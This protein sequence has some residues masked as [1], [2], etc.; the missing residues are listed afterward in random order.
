MAKI[1]AKGAAI[2]VDNS[3]G[4]PQVISSDVESYT[5]DY[6]VGTVDV[7]GFGEPQNFVPDVVI[8]KVSM[9]VKWNTAATTG[10]TTVLRT[11]VGHATS[12]TVSVTPEAAGIAFSGEFVCV[13]IHVEGQAQG[14]AIGLG[15]VEFLP[16]G[17][18]AG[19]WA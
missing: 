15:T 6:T 17:A 13:G 5:I 2:S 10:A 4:A 7:T 8:N 3:A 18:V 1:S 12:K 9:S 16:M 14:S 11:I 19:S